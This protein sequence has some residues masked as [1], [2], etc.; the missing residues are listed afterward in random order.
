M[1]SASGNGWEG[2]GEKGDGGIPT[3]QGVF[4][5]SGHDIVS[6]NRDVDEIIS[7]A[8]GWIHAARSLFPLYATI[9]CF[10]GS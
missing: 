6:S 5:Q 1:G 2:E 8:F 7:G 10:S 9:L 4:P 3:I